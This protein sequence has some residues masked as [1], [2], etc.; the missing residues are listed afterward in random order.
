MGITLV[1][2]PQFNSIPEMTK[3]RPLY[4]YGRLKIKVEKSQSRGYSSV[5][6]E[7]PKRMTSRLTPEKS[8]GGSS[9]LYVLHRHLRGPAQ[10]S[11]LWKSENDY[12]IRWKCKQ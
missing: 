2:F 12:L 9:E 11:S 6:E 4:D 10:S 7:W 3:R 1:L 5:S 8:G